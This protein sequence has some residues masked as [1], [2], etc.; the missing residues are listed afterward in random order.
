[1]A[2]RPLI[3][4]FVK[5]PFRGQVKSSLASK[6]GEDATLELYRNFGLDIL[7]TLKQ[8]G[9]PVR[10]CFYPPDSGK[11]VAGWLGPGQQY[12]PQEG[13]DMGERMENA[14]RQAFS[15]GFSRVVLI[16]SDIPDLPAP[17]LDDAMAAL[18]THHAVIGPARDGGYYLI[19]FRKDTFFPGVFS[20]IAWSTGTVFHST[21]QAFGRAGQRVHEL[22]L[23]QD[24]DTIKDL[25]DLAA[26][27]RRSAFRSSRTMSFLAGIKHICFSSE[28]SDA[29][30]RL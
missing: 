5:A 27:N 6:L 8:T 29:T 20:G 14:F 15:R 10:I 12:Q 28:G 26:R 3:I 13:R 24:V 25:K 17:L 16:G 4:L 9:I 21:I 2:D 7:D 19:G 30:I 18:L 22:P 23:W 1:M 11:T